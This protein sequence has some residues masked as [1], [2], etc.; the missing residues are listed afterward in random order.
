MRIDEEQLQENSYQQIYF[1]S[2]HLSHLSCGFSGGGT[3]VTQSGLKEVGDRRNFRV[4]HDFLSS[5]KN[6]SQSE[7]KQPIWFSVQEP[8]CSVCV[9]N[10]GLFPLANVS[11]AVTQLPTT[12]SNVV[13][14]FVPHLFACGRHFVG[15]RAGLQ[16]R[17]LTLCPSIRGLK[18]TS[19][20]LA[21]LLWD[22]DRE[23]K[24]GLFHSLLQEVGFRSRL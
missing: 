4:T 24:L 3:I 11:A 7:A 12:V 15:C 5:G 23:K 13:F 16:H 17:A 21:G 9:C 1:N 10:R 20:L 22:R 6:M 18:C 2:F 19:A 14:R 8:T